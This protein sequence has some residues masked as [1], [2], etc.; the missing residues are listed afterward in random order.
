MPVAVLCI[1]EACSYADIYGSF[2]FVTGKYPHFDA[3]CF[4][5]LDGVRHI[6]LESIFNG[7]GTD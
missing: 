6:V 3:S 4:S 7:R 5:E 2:Y 1:E